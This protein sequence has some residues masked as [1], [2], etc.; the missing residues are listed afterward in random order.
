MDEIVE[1][2]I[3]CELNEI[4]N[5]DFPLN[6]RCGL[7]VYINNVKYEFLINLKDSEQLLVLGSGARYGT[8]TIEQKHRPYFNRF[9][10]D[11]DTSTLNYNDPT[12]Y[13]ND[14]IVCG[15]GVGTKEDFYLENISIIIN[16]VAKN[17]GITPEN[18]V[19]YGSSAGGFMS[20]M[21]ST[22]I[23][24]SIAIAEIPQLD[25]TDYYPIHWNRIKK[26]CFGDIGEEEIKSKY[27]NRISVVEQIKKEKYIP[28]A[29]LILDCSCQEDYVNMYLPF[30]NI[31]NQLPYENKNHIRIRIDGKHQGHHVL[32]KESAMEL[33]KNVFKLHYENVEE[34]QNKNDVNLSK[35]ESH[36]A[37]LKS[38][39]MK[40]I[41]LQ[42]KNE[43]LEKLKEDN[44]K[45]KEDNEKLLKFK[46]DVLTSN[47]WKY[48]EFLRKI[49]RKTK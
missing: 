34:Y 44:R 16:E 15:W 10:W 30:F 37:K 41:H 35:L 4:K 18:M 8:Q 45:L 43:E 2:I 39:E 5:R 33:V 3:Q 40:T 12:T 21:L 36:E 32:D 29:Y 19:F 42:K 14:E 46:N 9:T 48:S 17:I 11:F 25:L 28:N 49:K 6:K 13:L 22:M 24:R 26:Y 31:L 20:I 7:V 38:Q 23:K 1:E 27:Y 47:T